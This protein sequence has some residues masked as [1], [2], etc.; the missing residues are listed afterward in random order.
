MPEIRKDPITG[1]RVILSPERLLRPF[2]SEPAPRPGDSSA[3][4]PFCPGHEDRTPP[5]LLAHRAPGGTRDG[6]GWALRVVP[7]KYPALRVEGELIARE[8]GMYE[9]SSGIGA[10]EVIIESPDH[11]RELAELSLAQVEAVLFAVR[12]RVLDLRNDSRI[13]YVLFFKNHGARAGATLDHGHAQLL[14]SPFVPKTILEELEGCRAHH[15][16]AER[17]LFCDLI[18]QEIRD[19]R[20]LVSEADRF[21][22]I[23]PYASRFPFETWILPK[24]HAAAFEESEPADLAA[25]AATLHDTLG[26]LRRALDRPHYNLVLHSTPCGEAR[27]DYYHWHVEILPRRTPLAGFEWASGFYINPTPPEEAARYLRE[28]EP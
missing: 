22:A 21:V 14:A 27:L 16:R 17:C 28:V 4:C 5:E 23:E 26:R 20:R 24:R 6:P 9:S 13:R 8:E 25:L 10:H 7:N 11:D 18:S 12:D 1:R 3:T 19:R 15:R 2:P